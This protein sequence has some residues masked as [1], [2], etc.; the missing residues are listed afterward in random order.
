M[1]CDL[2]L[3]RTKLGLCCPAQG[4]APLDDGTAGHPDSSGQGYITPHH[5][6]S[7]AGKAEKGV[8]PSSLLPTLTCSTCPGSQPRAS[9]PAQPVTPAA[10]LPQRGDSSGPREGPSAA[11]LHRAVGSEP[12]QPPTPEAK[13]S[14]VLPRAAAPSDLPQ[15]LRPLRH[16]PAAQRKQ[17]GFCRERSCRPGSQNAP[18]ASPPRGCPRMP[19]T[20]HPASLFHAVTALG[21]GRIK[22]RTLKFEVA[23]GLEREPRPVSSRRRAEGEG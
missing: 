2:S 10:C 21:R 14:L 5:T 20:G 1:K 6:R 23:A 11:G 18:A 17:S 19:V 3:P 22:S 8:R 7:E 15:A 4:P 12:R 9:S 16:N 13:T